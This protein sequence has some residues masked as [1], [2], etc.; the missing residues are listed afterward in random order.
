MK[1]ICEYCKLPFEARKSIQR[2]CK[3]P[4]TVICPICQQ[5][6]VTTKIEHLE[7]PVAC[8]YK[9]R[10]KKTKQ[11]SLRKYG[12]KAPGNNPQAREKAKNT[13]I[14]N[15]GVPYAM[16]SE[17]VKQKSIQTNLTKY[18]VENAG[19]SPEVINKRMKTNHEKYGDILPFNQPE[20]C[21]KQRKTLKE[22]YGVS[23]GFQTP[24]AINSSWIK[25]SKLNIEFQN[26]IV[27]IANKYP[28][29]EKY[30]DKKY[31]DV[32]LPND[33]LVIELNPTYTHTSYDTGY[34]DSKDKYYHRNKTQLA[35]DNGFKCIHVWDWDDQSKIL[36][37]LKD[38]I[39]VSA[40]ECT[41]M[42]LNKSTYD[43]FFEANDFAGTC[44]NIKL[45][46]GL[47]KDNQVYQAIAIGPAKQN[48]NY[49]VQIYRMCTRLGYEVAGGYDMIST[50]ISNYGFRN[51]IAYVDRSKSE[52]EE[53]ES[54]GMKRIRTT[55]PRKIWSKGKKYINS[56]MKGTMFKT[57][58]QLLADGW[59]PIYDCG[60]AVYVFQ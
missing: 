25:I 49:D 9:C 23:N 51:I 40:D 60:Q 39:I 44:R 38:K 15:H 54:L 19:S 48:K 29:L 53:Y 34:S 35:I 6:Y 56:S 1:K 58:E 11:T 3:R 27:K 4:H 42:Q 26:K 5:P 8:S 32:Y 47:I 30:I 37:N 41:L 18:G 24:N 52:G 43:E 50:F 33:N 46:I 59:L 12:C 13:C 55:P 10:A 21:E 57:E 45:C 20:A 16:Q 2:F 7:N 31:Y 22:R 28:E 36:L 17:T 14:K